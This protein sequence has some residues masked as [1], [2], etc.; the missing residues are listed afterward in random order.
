MFLGV[1]YG[2]IPREATPD[3]HRTTPPKSLQKSPEV[4]KSLHVR[5][6]TLGGIARSPTRLQILARADYYTLQ[7]YDRHNDGH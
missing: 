5:E 1:P 7:N 4:C 3:P 2:H 6:G